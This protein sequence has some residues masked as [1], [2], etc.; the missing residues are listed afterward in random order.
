M[1]LMAFR[2]R[3]ARELRHMGCLLGIYVMDPREA[4]TIRQRRSWPVNF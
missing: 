3:S 4:V 2:D 1:Q